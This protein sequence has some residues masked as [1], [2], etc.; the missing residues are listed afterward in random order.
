[1]MPS[2]TNA[3]KGGHLMSIIGWIV[4]GIIIGFVA[5]R[6]AH[7]KGRGI[8]PDIILGIAGSIVGGILFVE[9]T[10]ESVSRVNLHSLL[11]AIIGAILVLVAYH[12]IFDH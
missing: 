7:K 9:L 10:A 4:L 2:K 11:A 8:I 3:A 12:A 5:S 6:V 1:M